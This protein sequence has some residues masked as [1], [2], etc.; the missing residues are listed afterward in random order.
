MHDLL[1][2]SSDDMKFILTDHIYETGAFN[3]ANNDSN[4]GFATNWYEDS[5]LQQYYREMW[6]YKDKIAFKITGHD[7]L[8]DFR[9]H[10]SKNLFSV[11][12]QCNVELPF[13]EDPFL[14][15]MIT[16]SI[17]S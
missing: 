1:A 9:V 10:S 2:D 4:H 13:A 7:H 3:A 12:S 11:D 8:S 16:P 17:T 5:S 14:G 6:Q 15:K